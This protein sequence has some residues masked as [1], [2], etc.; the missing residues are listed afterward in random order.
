MH[1][2]KMY[3][4]AMV[5]VLSFINIYIYLIT[6]VIPRPIGIP[7]SITCCAALLH[8]SNVNFYDSVRTFVMAQL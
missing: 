5:E 6:L 4:F 1:T 3:T 2:K 7:L 8:P